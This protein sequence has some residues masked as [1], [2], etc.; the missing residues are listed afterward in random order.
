MKENA[1]LKAKLKKAVEAL[2]LVESGA[3]TY[4]SRDG[5]EPT[6]YEVAARVIK[7]IKGKS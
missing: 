6:C 4:Y 5:I 7:E 2:M 3:A 1:E